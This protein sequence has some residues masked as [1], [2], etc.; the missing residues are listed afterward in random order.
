VSIE[1]RW[2]KD[3]YD[4]LGV[5]ARDLVGRHASV[6]Q[7]RLYGHEE[8]SPPTKLS[9]GCRFRKETIA[10]MRRNGRDAPTADLLA[11]PFG[12]YL[13]R[14]H[15]ATISRPWA[16]PGRPTAHLPGVVRGKVRRQSREEAG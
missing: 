11:K 1:H 3:R 2:A 7:G 15:G 4:Q 9:A 6:E 13:R 8:R 16:A 10:A 5:I 12:V 14:A